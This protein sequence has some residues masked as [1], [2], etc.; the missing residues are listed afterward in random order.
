MVASMRVGEVLGVPGSPLMSPL[1][2]LRTQRS[3]RRSSRES[4]LRTVADL[5][6]AFAGAAVGHSA[7]TVLD[8][9]GVA[10]ERCGIARCH[11]P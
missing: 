4:F 8:F 6:V 5:N 10:F 9:I 7:W 2:L 3:L 11:V 1:I